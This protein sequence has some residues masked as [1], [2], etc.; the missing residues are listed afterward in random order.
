MSLTDVMPR[1]AVAGVVFVVD[2]SDRQRFAEAR[3]ELFHILS[4]NEMKE[5]PLVVVA[6]KS[7]VA[8]TQH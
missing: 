4:H 8:G 3:S 1:H 5:V 2:S 7:D 6:N